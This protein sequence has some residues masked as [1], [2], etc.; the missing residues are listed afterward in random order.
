MGILINTQI[1][2]QWSLVNIRCTCVNDVLNNTIDMNMR[3]ILF[4]KK[5]LVKYR[6]SVHRCKEKYAFNYAI[7]MLWQT[8]TQENAMH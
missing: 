7:L 3:R 5:H 2:L 8:C 6:C 4:W 1:I